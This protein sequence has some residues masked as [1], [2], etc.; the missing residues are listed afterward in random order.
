MQSVRRQNVLGTAKCGIYCP[1]T[2]GSTVSAVDGFILRNQL[3]DLHSCFCTEYKYVLS[4]ICI[5]KITYIYTYMQAYIFT[6]IFI[7]YACKFEFMFDN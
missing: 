5:C 4:S 7:V 3:Y 2:C 6:Y 1:W